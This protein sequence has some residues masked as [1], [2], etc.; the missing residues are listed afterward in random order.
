MDDMSAA[1]KRKL[2]ALLHKQTPSLPSNDFRR[3]RPDTIFLVLQGVIYA[4]SS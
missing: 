2:Q 1:K 4:T 3:R